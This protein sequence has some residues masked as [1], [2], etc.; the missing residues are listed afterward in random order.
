M[1]MQVPSLLRFGATLVAKRKT[2]FQ[3]TDEWNQPAE[4]VT[5]WDVPRIRCLQCG[6]K[7]V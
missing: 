6:G 3:R 7:M 2:W 1:G 5:C 4:R